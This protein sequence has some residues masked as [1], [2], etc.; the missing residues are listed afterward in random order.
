MKKD[1]SSPFDKLE[2]ALQRY[3]AG[4]RDLAGWVPRDLREVDERFQH[5]RRQMRKFGPEAPIEED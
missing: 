4:K 1:A 3:L 5:C 2:A